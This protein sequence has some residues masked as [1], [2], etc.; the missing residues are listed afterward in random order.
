VVPVTRAE[1]IL[2]P[3][4]GDLSAWKEVRTVARSHG[5]IFGLVPYDFR[6]PS[7]A[8]A[9]ETFWNGGDHR[10]LVPTFFGVGWTVNLRNAPRHP[11]QALLLVAFVIW[12]LRARWSAGRER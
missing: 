11:L 9:R 7:P 8:R 12:R 4:A 6:P 10:L 3:L 5:K 1:F 2:T